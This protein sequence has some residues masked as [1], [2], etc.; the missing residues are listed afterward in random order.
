MAIGI[1]TLTGLVLQGLSNSQTRR[2]RVSNE[3]TY[4]PG[5]L[6]L[7]SSGEL[8]RRERALWEKMKS[9]DLC[10][11]SCG[12]NRMAGKKG[13][14]SSDN[15]FKVASH[16]PHF[17]EER[18]LVGTHGSGTIF[19]S[20][21]NLLCV[22]CQNWE[23]NHRGDGRP[24]THVELANMMIS[25]Q[26]MGAH[27]INLVTPSHLVPH[28]VTALRLA[29]A[30][31][32]NIPLLYNSGGY[33]MLEVLQ[34]LDGIVDV[35]LP[36]FKYQDSK[37]AARFSE[38]APDYT[39]YTAAAI[40]EMHRQVGTLQ[41]VNGIAYR[42]LLIRHLVL[43]ENAAGTDVFV[44]WVVAELGDDTHVNIMGQ[45]SPQFKA[46]NYPP[47]NRRLTQKEFDQAMQW[48]RKVGLKNFH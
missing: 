3:N 5:Y 7:E 20:N 6:T 29:I 18:V 2:N 24:T 22:F 12:T 39:E 28:I 13:M 30:K 27:N 26:R 23:I 36:D 35:Y 37:L 16:G 32:L 10:P 11:R 42:G 47:L 40:K 21:C 14:C 17:G 38:G 34:L 41:Q 25:L 31:G 8:E 15:T 48:A 1:M 9:C 33:E 46:N 4:K 44:R 43:P 45:Y 19:F